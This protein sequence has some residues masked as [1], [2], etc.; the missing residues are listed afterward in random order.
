MIDDSV[1]DEPWAPWAP[2]A[3]SPEWGSGGVGGAAPAAGTAAASEEDMYAS[4]GISEDDWNALKGDLH[5]E[6]RHAIGQASPPSGSALSPTPHPPG[7]PSPLLQAQGSEARP[8]AEG[9]LWQDAL[10]K[11]QGGSLGRTLADA[12]YPAVALLRGTAGALLPRPAHYVEQPGTDGAACVFREDQST[13]HRYPQNRERPDDKWQSHRGRNASRVWLPPELQHGRQPQ[14]LI[15]RAGNVTRHGRSPLRFHRYEIETVGE[16][17]RAPSKRTT[18]YHVLPGTAGSNVAKKQR[19]T[20]TTLPTI[21]A[22]VVFG[23]TMRSAPSTSLPKAFAAIFSP[24]PSRPEDMWLRRVEEE[25]RGPHDLQLALSAAAE[26]GAF[27]QLG[28]AFIR[29][30]AILVAGMAAQA[31]DPAAIFGALC[32]EGKLARWNGRMASLLEVPASKL[33]RESAIT[34]ACWVAPGV[35]AFTRGCLPVFGAI[36]V[37]DY[38]QFDA[39]NRASHPVWRERTD[40]VPLKLA[41]LLLELLR[42]DETGRESGGLDLLAV[43]GGWLGIN[44]C[45]TY[46]RGSSVSE[47][48]LSRGVFGTMAAHLRA[49]GGP[50]KWIRISQC[51]GIGAVVG[52]TA[53]AACVLRHTEFVGAHAFMSSGLCDEFLGAVSAFARAGAAGLTDTINCGL[54]MVLSSLTICCHNPGC[55]AKLQALSSELSYCLDHSLDMCA[56]GPHPPTRCSPC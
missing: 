25:S 52:I 26:L 33:D 1:V 49:L 56:H 46:Q 27:D 53:T 2:W 32:G 29:R 5:A 34:F 45:L 16:A 31:V 18:L 37:D 55:R 24:V 48:L 36:G 28:A 42:D 4:L 11:A 40:G 41:T 13:P 10:S 22:G 7:P 38:A 6:I 43:G 3:I 19:T 35:L 23:A 9:A 17:E 47:H 54:T 44:L 20:S 30:A 51:R 12:L 14:R 15:R 50:E 21:D 8:R 39:A